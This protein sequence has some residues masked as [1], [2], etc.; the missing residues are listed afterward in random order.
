M[1]HSVRLSYAK[2]VPFP[3]AL[4]VVVRRAVL[5]QNVREPESRSFFRAAVFVFGALPTMI[6]AVTIRGDRVSNW[7]VLA[8]FV[9]FVILELIQRVSELPTLAR[10]AEA[11]YR[12]LKETNRAVVAFGLIA[13]LFALAIHID[14]CLETL[15][16]ALGKAMFGADP[17]SWQNGQF[18]ALFSAL[19]AAV[20]SSSLEIY[21]FAPKDVRWQLL[22]ITVGIRSVLV[23]HNSVLEVLQVLGH[24][25]KL[26]STVSAIAFAIT[27]T[28]AHSFVYLLF[29]STTLSQFFR[30]E[31]ER[32]QRFM[33]QWIA[34]WTVACIFLYYGYLYNA[35]GTYQPAWTEWLP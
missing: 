7:L 24:W 5:Y 11:T 29:T 21:E 12:M 15:D 33:E 1:H 35:A 10:S 26:A 27:G 25:S 19:V 4:R 14:L 18:I 28:L 22:L 17:L 6:K 8:Y 3:T 34:L 16:R 23:L 31:G 2:K 32:K 13:A 30:G 9:P 20:V